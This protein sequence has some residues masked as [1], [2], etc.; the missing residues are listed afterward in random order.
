M[1]ILISKNENPKP[2]KDSGSIFFLLVRIERIFKQMS[3]LISKNEN[4]KSLKDSGSILF[5]YFDW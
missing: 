4:P 3:I 2:L 5:I 1:S